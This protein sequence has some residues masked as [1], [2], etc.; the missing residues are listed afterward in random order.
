MLELV[1]TF[2]ERLRI[3]VNN[4]P[5]TKTQIANESGISKS[6][7]SHYLAGDNEAG[8][9]KLK[10][11]AATLKVSP[12]WLIGYDCPMKLND[13]SDSDIR[14]TIDNYLDLMDDDK[15]RKTLQFIKDYI[16]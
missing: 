15:L 7:L 1:S 16:L 14:T 11:L 12:V 13:S 8:N 4:S 6:L 10:S 5:L 3:A 2:K 9:D